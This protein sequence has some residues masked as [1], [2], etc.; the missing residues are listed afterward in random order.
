MVKNLLKHE[1]R[2]T[3]FD[4]MPN[5]ALA[6]VQ[7][8]AIPAV[9]VTDVASHSDIIFSSYVRRTLRNYL[10]APGRI[11]AG[12]AIVAVGC[13]V[14]DVD[15]GLRGQIDSKAARAIEK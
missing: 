8:G 10:A 7:Y 9:S 4:V 11:H 15:R 2:V 6:L 5:A 12:S 1:Y 14:H 13:V 3:V